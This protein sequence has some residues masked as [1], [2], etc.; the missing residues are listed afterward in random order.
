MVSVKRER[1]SFCEGPT[2][3]LLKIAQS[4]LLITIK[5]VAVGHLLDVVIQ[6]VAG[7]PV[8]KQVSVYN[9]TRSV[10]AMIVQ[11]ISIVVQPADPGILRDGTGIS[12]NVAAS[13]LS[14]SLFANA[15][16]SAAQ[17]RS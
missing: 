2:R 6:A 8:A 3:V 17:V 14:R 5:S 16:K 15:Y 9:T 4:A 10:H 12:V 1:R 11:G 7:T 13:R